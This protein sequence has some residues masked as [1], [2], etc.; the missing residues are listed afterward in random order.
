M[1]RIRDAVKVKSGATESVSYKNI[2]VS[3]SEAQ[4][5]RRVMC[6][7]HGYGGPWFEN[8]CIRTGIMEGK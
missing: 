4:S 3:K 1:S 2:G 5:M 6:E 8:Y 7:T